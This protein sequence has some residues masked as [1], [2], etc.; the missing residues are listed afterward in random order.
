MARTRWI[1]VV[2]C[3]LLWAIAAVPALGQ[4]PSEASPRHD[5][6]D[7]AFLK[8]ALAVNELEL[9]L[10]RLAG[11]Q[12]TTAEVKS[13]GKNMV[14]KHTELGQKLSVLAKQAGVS[15]E[16]ALTADQQETF[17]H[18]KSQTGPTFDRVFK[19]TVDDGH[20]SELAMYR[21]EVSRAT[22]PQL[23][24]L[25]EDRVTALQKSMAAAGQ[26]T[27]PS[28]SGTGAR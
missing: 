27:E 10:G 13:M 15:P 20:V 9:R 24:R 7:G 23:R 22:N 3:G 28:E 25:A 14:Q 16:P 21:D 1:R 5:A 2:V 17:A 26:R 4:P 18:V 6:S 8:Q 19:Q 12:A 11:E